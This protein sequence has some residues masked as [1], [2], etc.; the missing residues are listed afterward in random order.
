MKISFR[1]LAPEYLEGLLASSARVYGPASYQAS[2][3]YLD[4]LYKE[5]PF[6]QG[7]ETCLIAVSDGDVVGCIHRMPLPLL[8]DEAPVTLMSLQNHFILPEL[9]GGAGIM[10]LRR[11]AEEHRF[12]FSPGVSGRLGDAYRRFGFFELPSYWLVRQI[13]PVLAALQM[14]RSRLGHHDPVVS[15]SRRT[16]DKCSKN[17]LVTDSPSDD[18]LA[19][20]A[21]HMNRQG[22]DADAARVVWTADLVRWRFFSEGGPIHLLVRDLHANG[23]AVLSYGKR[24]GV[25]VVRLVEYAGGGNPR[26]MSEIVRWARRMGAAIGLAYS[27]RTAF[28][29]E[30]LASGWQSRRHA[31]SSFAFGTNKLSVSGGTSDVGLEAFNTRISQ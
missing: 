10:L 12:G 21:S 25:T 30:L 31:P 1:S 24:S 23:W 26:F 16:L 4:W 15:L 20:L 6:S 14:A 19:D 13:S 29:D 18:Q 9:R 27:T 17:V 11:A 5:H 28:R 22:S 3:R 2:T 8:V 7:L